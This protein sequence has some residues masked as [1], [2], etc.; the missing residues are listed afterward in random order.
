MEEGQSFRAFLPR[1]LRNKSRVA[2]SAP[3]F[4]PTHHNSNEEVKVTSTLWALQLI[5]RLADFD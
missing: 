5:W 3:R 2:S 4:W 1:E